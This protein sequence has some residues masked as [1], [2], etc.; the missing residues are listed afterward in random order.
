MPRQTRNSTSLDESPDYASSSAMR[1]K[2][3]RGHTKSRNGCAECKRRHIRC[4]ERRPSCAN[5]AVAE[6]IC[7]FPPPKKKRGKQ[8][9]AQEQQSNETHGF[10]PECR[11]SSHSTPCVI[12]TAD[13]EHPQIPPPS[14]RQHTRSDPERAPNNLSQ[15]C[16]LRHDANQFLSGLELND[17]EVPSPD[18]SLQLGDMH[19]SLPSY[20]GF[21]EVSDLNSKATFTSQHMILLYHAHIVPNICGPNRIVIDIAIRRAVD[22]P[23]LLDE[24]LAFIAFH[25]TYLYPGSAI[26]LRHLA[27]ELQTRAVASFTSLTESVPKDDRAT[28]VPRFLFSAILGRHA[29]ADTLANYRSDFQTFIDRLVECFSLN[30]GVTSVTPPARLYLHDSEIKPLLTV[31]LDAYAK[32]LTPGNECDPLRRLLDDSDLS[33]TSTTACRQAIEILQCSFDICHHLDVEDYP[34]SASVF[35]VKVEGGF[36]DMLRKHRP[37]ALVILAYFGVLLH[38]CHGFWAFGDAGAVM[39]RAIA[40]HLGSYWQAPLAWPLH[41]I[42]MER[43]PEPANMA[44]MQVNSSDSSR[45]PVPGCPNSSIPS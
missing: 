29:L 22:S 45:T 3:R 36:V 23:Y 43:R 25:M 8:D 27:T 40:G 21:S 42:E 37:E 35:S 10:S 38:R 6:R 31:V 17:R 11:A 1:T 16:S 4:D 44:S 33:E 19:T 26:H 9:A 12:D 2:T 30:R 5:C 14:R 7:F 15:T 34:Q 32:V 28:A 41:V 39:I 13:M 20:P 24:V 18:P